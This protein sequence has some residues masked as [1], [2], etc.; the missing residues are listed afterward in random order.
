MCKQMAYS[1]RR[2]ASETNHKK[3]QAMR[4]KSLHQM[5]LD[6]SFVAKAFAAV[7]AETWKA[8]AILISSPS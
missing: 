6:F 5:Y 7:S 1:F 8:V 4:T 2:T 3:E